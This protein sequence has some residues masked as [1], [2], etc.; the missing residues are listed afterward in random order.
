MNIYSL[1][2]S[3]TR[4]LSCLASFIIRPVPPTI[5]NL[6]VSIILAQTWLL[7]QPPPRR[8]EAVLDHCIFYLGCECDCMTYVTLVTVSDLHEGD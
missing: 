5:F 2:N 4:S 3:P 8:I 1:Y 7:G 6:L